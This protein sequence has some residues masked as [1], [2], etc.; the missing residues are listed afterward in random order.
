MSQMDR[1]K[2]KYPDIQK[3]G[4]NFANASAT[5]Q[6]TMEQKWKNLTNGLDALA[7][8]F[9][10]ALLPAATKLTGA[11]SKLVNWFTKGGTEANIRPVSSAGR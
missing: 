2:S 9:G 1:L 7:I 4:D 5:Q 11:L 3:A 6:K 8:K 10:T